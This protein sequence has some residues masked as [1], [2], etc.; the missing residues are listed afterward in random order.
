M[1]LC[2]KL[3]WGVWGSPPPGPSTTESYAALLY[4]L[5]LAWI[6]LDAGWGKFTDPAQSW[7]AGADVPALDAYIRHT[8]VSQVIRAT[9]PEVMI[10]WMTPTVVWAELAIPIA[11]LVGTLMGWKGMVKASGA[12][13]M[14]LHVGI[15]LCMNG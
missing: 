6:Y 4:R 9:V 13:A 14:A 11:M 2:S 1:P 12:A 10:R 8:P 3:R 15:G 5:Q 7:T